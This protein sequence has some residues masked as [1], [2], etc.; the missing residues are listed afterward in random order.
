MNEVQDYKFYDDVD[1]DETEDDSDMD[2]DD[3]Q[4]Q[5]SDKEQLTAYFLSLILG[6]YHVNGVS[7]SV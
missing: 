6:L 7:E 3:E 1:N 2:S 4:I 5:Y